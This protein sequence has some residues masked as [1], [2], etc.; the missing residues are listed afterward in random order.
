[1]DITNIVDQ[2]TEG[3]GLAVLFVLHLRHHC[4]INKMVFVAWLLVDPSG[5]T[6]NSVSNVLVAEF[7][8]GV[9]I[10]R[11]SFVKERSID[12][13]PVRLPATT[14]VLDQISKGG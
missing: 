8:F 4:L 3:I 10:K 1:M 12:K 6:L 9:I 14:M 13:M 11:A 5:D 2:K 7:D